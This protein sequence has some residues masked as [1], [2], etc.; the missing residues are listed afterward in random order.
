MLHAVDGAIIE[1][2]H[3]RRAQSERAWGKCV[4]HASRALEV[5]ISSIELRELRLAC[6][7]EAGDVDGVYGDLT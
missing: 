4:E 3:A 5:G 1:S 6:E 7:E 2:G